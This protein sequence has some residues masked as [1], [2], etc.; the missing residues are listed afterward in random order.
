MH[1]HDRTLLARLGFS[2]PDK[3]DPRHDLACQYLALPENQERFAEMFL[4]PQVRRGTATWLAG[5][6]ETTRARMS[7]YAKLRVQ[8]ELERP[9]S[10]GDGK[11]KTT[12]GFIDLWCQWF[13]REERAHEARKTEDYYRH[14]ETGEVSEN[15]R[16]RFD[17]G[18]VTE[19]REVWTATNAVSNHGMAAGV[20]VK[21]APSSL[22]DVL[23]QVKLYR[24]YLDGGGP[25]WPIFVLATTYPVSAADTAALRAER[26]THVRLGPKFDEWVAAQR[27]EEPP[28]ESPEF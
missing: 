7:R 8:T 19:H 16:V 11:F 21:V 24:E 3:K 22:G 25:G 12:V 20:E 14:A 5:A 15:A 4:W 26:I 6:S 17:P 28:Q 27:T 9:V 2:D 1:S 13:I 10:K 23:R 18:W